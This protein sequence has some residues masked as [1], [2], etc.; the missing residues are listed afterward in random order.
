MK[1][2]KMIGVL[3]TIDVMHEVSL[4]LDIPEDHQD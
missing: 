4:M 1:A 3:R 2:G